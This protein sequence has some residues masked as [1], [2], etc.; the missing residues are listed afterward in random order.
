MPLLCLPHMA[1]TVA[2]PFCLFH[3]VIPRQPL[4][5]ALWEGVEK[6]HFTDTPFSEI[7]SN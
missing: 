1:F 3:L 4:Q 6:M 7:S 2:P 5:N